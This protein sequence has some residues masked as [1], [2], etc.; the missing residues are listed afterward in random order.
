MK[1]FCIVFLLVYFSSEIYF[2]FRRY[3]LLN[4][5]LS[6]PTDISPVPG[7]K[8]SFRRRLAYERLPDDQFQIISE[9]LRSLS[10]SDPIEKII[11]VYAKILFTTLLAVFT[12]AVTA[13]AAL[14]PLYE[15]DE[16]K[17]GKGAFI[18]TFISYLGL[19][20]TILL[21]ALTITIITALHFFFFDLRNNL[22]HAHLTTIEAIEKSR[23]N[24]PQP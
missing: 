13:N 12:I 15:M 9:G 16:L 8:S 3:L 17:E 1:I 11:D 22:T 20:D 23:Q 4:Q 18:K 19:S 10:T 21:S 24:Q 7:H 14:L 6:K 5:P 2:T